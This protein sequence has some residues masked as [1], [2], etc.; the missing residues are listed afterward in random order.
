MHIP[1]LD[2]SI[3]PPCVAL[4]ISP[5]PAR[6]TVIDRVD[7]KYISTDLA[8][9]LFDIESRLKSTDDEPPGSVRSEFRGFTLNSYT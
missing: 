9:Y 7:A 8:G 1:S 3:N 6:R 4:R 5:N 2:I